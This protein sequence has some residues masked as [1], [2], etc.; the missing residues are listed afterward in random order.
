MMNVNVGS[1][2]INVE[3]LKSLDRNSSGG[4]KNTV[5]PDFMRFLDWADWFDLKKGP[6]RGY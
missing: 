3:L 5:G 1:E 6:V 4:L 2:F